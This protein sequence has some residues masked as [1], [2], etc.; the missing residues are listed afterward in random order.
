MGIRVSNLTAPITRAGSHWIS[1]IDDPITEGLTGGVVIHQSNQNV[2]HHQPTCLKNTVMNTG[3]H[4]ASWNTYVI[5]CQK[6]NTIGSVTS[7]SCNASP[8]INTNVATLPIVEAMI[9]IIFTPLEKAIFLNIAPKNA[10]CRVLFMIAMFF[11]PP[12]SSKVSNVHFEG[13]CTFWAWVIK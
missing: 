3:W 9:H 1:N 7:A 8:M 12:L 6:A 5:C 13:L 11:N 2:T 4:E 10:T